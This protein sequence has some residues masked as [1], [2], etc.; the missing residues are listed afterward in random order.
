MVAKQSETQSDG[1][2]L[3]DWNGGIRCG[4]Q[5]RSPE[6]VALEIRPRWQKT[7]TKQNALHSVWGE[8][9][10]INGAS[11][12]DRKEAKVVRTGCWVIHVPIHA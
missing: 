12:R 5:L 3:C 11:S 2:H 9:L 7:K 1:V 10:Q 8:V 4:G 6:E